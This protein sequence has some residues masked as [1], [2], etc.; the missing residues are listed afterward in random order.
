MDVPQ[1][2]ATL[3]VVCMVL[4]PD[5]AAIKVKYFSNKLSTRVETRKA[6]QASI[7][8]NALTQQTLIKGLRAK[9]L[10]LHGF[11]V[12]RPSRHFTAEN[13]EASF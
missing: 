12:D 6:F 3:A 7:A 8:R 13:P 2:P 10:L 11:I 9:G 1:Q 5:E 4:I